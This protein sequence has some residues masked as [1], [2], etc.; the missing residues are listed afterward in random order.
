MFFS[1]QRS[2]IRQTHLDIN[3]HK[4]MNTFIFSGA[5][6]RKMQN[7]YKNMLNM[8]KAFSSFQFYLFTNFIN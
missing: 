3:R 7:M 4:R 6:P 5:K 8:K 2:V 1:F